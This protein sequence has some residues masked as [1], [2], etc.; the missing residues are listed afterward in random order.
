MSQKDSQKTTINGRTYEV[1][2]LPPLV[3]QDVLIDI[4]QAFAPAAPEIVA[5]ATSSAIPGEALVSGQDVSVLSKLAAS[6]DKGKMRELCAIMA[7]YTHCNGVPLE[8]TFDETFR[9]DLPSLYKWL[10]FC[11]AVQ[12]GNFS[13]PVQSALRQVAAVDGSQGQSQST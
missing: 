4:L 12:F 5:I 11:L 13:G 7:K 8:P 1:F 6:L 9:G 2:K 10:W 3:A